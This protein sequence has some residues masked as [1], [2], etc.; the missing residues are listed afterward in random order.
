MTKEEIAEYKKN[1]SFIAAGLI[2]LLFIQLIITIA[3]NLTQLQ[4][5]MGYDSSWSFLKAMLIWREK[6]LVS[7]IWADTTGT[8][9]DGSIV[10]ASVLYGITGNIYLS[11]G[12]CN[13]VFVIL[14]VLIMLDVA[15]NFGLDLK[16]RLVCLNLLL[17][18]FLL[19]GISPK[20]LGYFTVLL[21]GDCL[22]NVRVIAFLMAVDA[23]LLMIKQEKIMKE[24]TASEKGEPQKSG[25]KSVKLHI[26]AALTSFLSFISGMS[27]GVYLLLVCF[28]PLML[29][30]FFRAM[31][32]NDSKQL[33]DKKMLFSAAGG[34]CVVL[35]KLFQSFFIPLSTAGDEKTWSTIADIWKNTGAVFQGFMKLF[36]VLPLTREVPVFSAEGMLKIPALA[37]AFL[38]ITA[39]LWSVNRGLRAIK[40]KNFES[41]LFIPLIVILWNIVIF[42]LFK[43]QYGSPV[44]EERYLICAF[45]SI[46]LL[47]GYCISN[48][49][50]KFLFTKLMSW[51]LLFTL[52]FTDIAS[53]GI[54]LMLTNK[55]W[56]MDEIARKADELDAGVVLFCGDDLI[57]TGRAMRVYDYDRIY[58]CVDNAGNI[59]HWGDY[60]FYDDLSF[61]DGNIM[62]VV[63]RD[64]TGLKDGIL[65]EAVYSGNCMQYDIYSK[66]NK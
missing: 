65:N 62:Y 45:V 35:G 56:H 53:D 28:I 54:F 50:D 15:K 58:K 40:N 26:L 30:S 29:Y 66:R 46:M 17:C 55:D 24:E 57:E 41:V 18:P 34:I 5:H 32:Q 63:S 23:V 10:P 21:C 25:N 48:I 11:Y 31:T 59:A 7:D 16:G 4:S 44:F 38:V 1:K 12:I 19:N 27:A 6:S 52:A 49:D 42:S 13:S 2:L 43:V 51:G 36:N 64:S 60:H 22:Y 3:F 9:L 33:Y 8:L 61:Y 20:N 37:V 47:A 14:L 39:M